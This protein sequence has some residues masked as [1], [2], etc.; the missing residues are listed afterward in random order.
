[1]KK[2]KKLSLKQA[3][4]RTFAGLIVLPLLIV[5]ALSL[6]ILGKN[7]KEQAVENI[8]SVQKTV[9]AGL[10]SDADF[11]SM[12]LSQITNVNNNMIMQYAVDLDNGNY[13]ERYEYQ[14]LLDQA[15]NM[16]IEPVKDVVSVAFYMK[17][18][19]EIFLKSHIRRSLEEIREYQWYQDALAQPN[20]VKIG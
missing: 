13:E 10:L 12:R 19:N 1:M 2:R 11:M 3:Y 15:G 17:S 6:L 16:I 9:A 8:E 20:S 4:Y 5:L 7:Y 14:E 18:G